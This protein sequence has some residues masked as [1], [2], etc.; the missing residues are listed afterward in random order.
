MPAEPALPPP[1]PQRSRRKLAQTLAILSVAAAIVFGVLFAAIAWARRHAEPIVRAR[2]VRTLE[3]RLHEPVQLDQL[4]VSINAGWVQIGGAGLRVTSSAGKPLLSAQ[5]FEFS[6]GLREI[7]SRKSALVKVHVQG[8][9]IDIPAGPERAQLQHQT[10]S[11]N[12]RQG[13]FSIVEV[14]A[15]DATLS[16]DR[17][18]PA[19]PPLVFQIGK[20][21]FSQSMPGRP[22]VYEANLI[23]PKPVG[24]I[25]STGRFGPWNASV[26]RN[27]PIDGTYTF[28]HA[29]LS[30]IPGIR[31]HLDGQGSITGTLGEITSD[32]T[33]KIPDFGID[34][35]VTDV[36]LTARYHA[37]VDGTSGDVLL[38]P[39]NAHFLH[40]EIV[41]SGHVARVPG[42]PGETHH[43]K[44]I[45]LDTTLH[46]RVE[47][48]LTLISK[49]KAPFLRATLTQ[50]GRMH[51]PP[52]RQRVIL[53]IQ[54][55][56]AAALS[57]ILWSDPETQQKVDSLSM[58]AQG[59]ADALADEQ[60]V[61]PQHRAPL[62]TSNIDTR[63]NLDHGVLRLD[64]LAYAMPGA[65]VLMDGAFD[66]PGDSL[67]F[68]G[69]VRTQ[70]SPS[71]MLS[72][73]KSLLLK[74]FDPLFKRNGAGLQLPIALT[75]S[76]AKPRIGLDMG[77]HDS[78]KPA[79]GPPT[80]R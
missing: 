28:A 8:L 47:D 5:S 39:V 2:I 49:G 58:R 3:D 72:G 57:G 19:K 41:A 68:H 23:N 66:I 20:L 1:P 24:E 21:R 79:S 65:T 55:S 34:P 13:I 17:L 62:V 56:G 54:T 74:P 71:E 80:G 31:G 37:V 78:G 45:L 43:G 36:A 32:G 61:D 11:I 42:A 77:H 63:F 12:P 15:T 60:E 44:D 48:I 38:M 26:P 6:T 16:V 46:G 67:D 33:T 35:G 52:G 70:A 18:D 51:I 14:V 53:R 75:G 73:W 22:F 4:H 9:H 69:H 27:T 59:H 76:P 7:L 40:T 29:D 30:T 10:G 50:R 25:H 64:G